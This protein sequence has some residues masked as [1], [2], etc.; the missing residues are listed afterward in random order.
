M[1][2]GISTKSMLIIKQILSSILNTRIPDKVVIMSINKLIKKR[3]FG[4]H[5]KLFLKFK[6]Q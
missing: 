1:K 3:N 4:M 6:M 5:K 2:G